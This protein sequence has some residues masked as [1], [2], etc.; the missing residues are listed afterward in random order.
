MLVFFFFFLINFFLSFILFYLIFQKGTGCL[1][2]GSPCLDVIITLVEEQMFRGDRDGEDGIH[3]E[4][5]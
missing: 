1:V 2:F 4:P 5:H 3:G